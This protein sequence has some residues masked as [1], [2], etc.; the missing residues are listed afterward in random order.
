MPTININ[1]NVRV[2]TVA[3]WTADVTVYSA[4]TILI[5]SDATYTGVDQ[6]KFKIADGVQAWANLDYMPIDARTLSEILDAGNQANQ[7]ID[8][9]SNSIQNVSFLGTGNSII[10]MGGGSYIDI[11]TD[12]GVHVTPNIFLDAVADTVDLNASSVMKNGNEV[13]TESYVNN[14]SQPLDSDLTAIAGLTP[15]NNDILQRKSGSWTNRTMDQLRTDLGG[16][17]TTA[18]TFAEG[19]DSRLSDSRG[20]KIIDYSNTLSGVTGTTTETLLKSLLIPANTVG[21]NDTVEII[22][23]TRAVGTAGIKTYRVYVN[24]SASLSGATL[25]GTFA[26]TSAMLSGGFS[27]FITCENSQSTQSVPTATTSSASMFG[28]FGSAS[29]INAN[30]ANDVYVLISCELA[31][32]ADTGRISSVRLSLDKI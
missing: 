26:S 13:A 7:D 5:S 6:R 19:N 15:T 32:A 12:A 29:T 22:A 14:Y 30:F 9:N 20:R 28:N 21:A 3:N 2:N 17:G 24:T 8:M 10:D 31:S 25:V 11:T 1:G 4:K 16:F 23:Q 27:K 18:G